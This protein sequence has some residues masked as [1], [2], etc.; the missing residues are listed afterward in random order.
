MDTSYCKEH[1]KIQEDDSVRKELKEEETG[2]TIKKWK[3]KH[4]QC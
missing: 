4:R 3:L 2:R 1:P